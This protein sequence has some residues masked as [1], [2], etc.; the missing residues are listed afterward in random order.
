LIWRKKWRFLDNG[1]IGSRFIKVISVYLGDSG[2]SKRTK[3]LM[4]C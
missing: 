2:R 4:I 3:Y 1:S